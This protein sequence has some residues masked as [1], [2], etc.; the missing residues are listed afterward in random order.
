MGATRVT[1]DMF[2][3][4]AKALAEVSPSRKDPKANLLPPLTQIRAVSKHVAFAVA[5]EAVQAGLSVH[6][7]TLSDDEIMAMVNDTMWEP[8]YLP[9]RY[10]AL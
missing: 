1:D 6:P 4:A 9:Y 5:K 10:A 2:L 3:T 7:K 8:V